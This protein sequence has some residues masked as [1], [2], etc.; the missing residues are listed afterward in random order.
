MIPIN[1]FAMY[2]SIYEKGI[3]KNMIHVKFKQDSIKS[4][5]NIIA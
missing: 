5:V 4:L 1:L 2:L 3:R